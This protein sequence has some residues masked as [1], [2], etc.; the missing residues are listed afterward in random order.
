MFLKQNKQFRIINTIN[1]KDYLYKNQN[2]GL[3]NPFIYG[4]IESQRNNQKRG[5]SNVLSSQPD[6]KSMGF[7][8]TAHKKR[9]N[10]T[11]A[12]IAREEFP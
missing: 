9:K 7:W 10:F 1:I 12:A 2:K 6:Q 8:L 3:T 5:V 11:Q 4:I